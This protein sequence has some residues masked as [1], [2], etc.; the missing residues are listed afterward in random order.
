V[1]KV[2]RRSFLGAAGAALST[3]LLRSG[4]SLAAPDTLAQPREIHSR[5]GVLDTTITAAAGTV[6]L[7]SDITF[8][9][10]LY[11]N[12]YLPPVLRL[13]T[14][15]VLRIRFRNQL[16]SDP[17]NLHFHGLGVSPSGHSDNV[18]VHVHPGTG[19]EYEVRIPAHDRQGPGLF[20]YHPHAH[21]V[22]AKQILGG[23][24][25]G[26][27]IEGFERYFPLVADLPERLLLI[28]HAEIAEREIIT[29]NGQLNPIIPIRPGEV[30]FWRIGHIGATLFTKLRIEG[31]PFYVLATDGH[32]LSRPQRTDE[33][34]IGPG[35]RVEA[36]VIGPPAGEYSVHTVSFQNEAWKTPDPPQR[37]ATLIASGKPAATQINE[38]GILRQELQ[39]RRWIEEI[40]R[41]P[42]ARRRQLNYSR[43]PDRHAFMINGQVMDEARV[44]QIARLGTTEE[45]TI[46]NTDAQ[47]H[48][49]HI[50]QTAFLVTHVNGVPKRSE[51]LHD[52]FSIPPATDFG[53]SSLRVIIPF[54]DPVIRGKFVYHCHAV[55]HEDKGMMGIIEVRG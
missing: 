25:G 11:N 32:A 31:L 22:V 14:G 13:R 16:P 49:F 29:L 33:L 30:Q 46:I 50:H 27:V 4:P 39:G 17:S 15:D 7:D 42:I 41:A 10:F 52:T 9:G 8:P 40:R 12:A 19:F 54:T 26:I 5:Q 53:P 24:S 1:T 36:I 6:N 35:E 51:S 37:I 43:T 47:F 44:D 45:W 48:S 23:L 34:F 28:K 2:D 21:G 3:S 38:A 55:D 18:F 20:W